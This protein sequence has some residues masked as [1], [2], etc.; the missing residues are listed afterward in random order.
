MKHAALLI[1]AGLLPVGAVAQTPTPTAT[2]LTYEA[3]AITRGW[4]IPSKPAPATTGT[5]TVPMVARILTITPTGACTFNA[6]GGVTGNECTF[7]IT[8]SGTTAR[9]LTWGTNF[10]SAG[11][12]STGTATAKRFSVTFLCLDGTTWVE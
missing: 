3:M 12:L 6:V 1:V 10:I 8:T 2:P 4:T 5:M 9:V 11:T 7:L